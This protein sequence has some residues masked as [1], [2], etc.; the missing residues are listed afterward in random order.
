MDSDVQL[1]AKLLSL[2]ITIHLVAALVW[3]H[4]G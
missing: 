3:H 1:A 4:P 2:F